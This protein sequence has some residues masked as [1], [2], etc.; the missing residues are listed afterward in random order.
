MSKKVYVL[1]NKETGEVY[2]S[3]MLTPLADLVDK[4]PRTLMNWMNNPQISEK[5]GYDVS[6]GKHLKGK[7][8]KNEEED[9]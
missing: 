3:F 6:I 4:D 7:K 1:K 2:T 9:T 8:G 5:R